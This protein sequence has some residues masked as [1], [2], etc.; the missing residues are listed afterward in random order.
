MRSS[1]GLSSIL[2]V[3]VCSAGSMLVYLR[4]SAPWLL[5][6]VRLIVPAGFSFS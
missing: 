1:L 2:G 5:L 3:S 4:I 6:N